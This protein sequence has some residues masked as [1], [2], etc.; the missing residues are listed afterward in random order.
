[1]SG[2]EAVFDAVRELKC[3]AGEALGRAAAMPVD[4]QRGKRGGAGGADAHEVS[5]L[6]ST[7]GVVGR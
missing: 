2:A 5:I 4:D 1:M 7:T 3:N 6:I